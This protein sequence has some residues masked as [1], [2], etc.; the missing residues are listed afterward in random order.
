MTQQSTHQTAFT[1]GAESAQQ[2][3]IDH[4]PTVL[5][6]LSMM[7]TIGSPSE[8]HYLTNMRQYVG[9]L[10]TEARLAPDARVLDIGSGC[11]R[12]ATGFTR[13]LSPQGA[14]TGI[15]VWEDGVRWCTDHLTQA[16]PNFIFQV[17]PAA[18]NYYYAADSGQANE[19]NLS[20]LPSDSYDGV[21][22]LSVFTHLRLADAQQYFALINRLL[23][24]DGRA[25]LTFFVIDEDSHRF[26][27]ETGQHTALAPAGDG[28]W[29]AYEKQWFFSG[30]EEPLLLRQFEE[31]GLEVCKRSPGS[32]AQK[33]GARLYQDW[34]L[35]RRR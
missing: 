17:V 29:Y 1:R 6:P 20:F 28:M 25:Y 11:G 23:K 16:H 27:R 9:D 2:S 13:Y 19:F 26:V 33:P 5:P 14:Y 24:R 10:I 15:D 3:L 30:Y 7:N 12:I 32:W 4:P 31:H 18:N 35:L 34:F 22:A 21:F 8:E